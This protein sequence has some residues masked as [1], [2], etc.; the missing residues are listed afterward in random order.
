MLFWL[1]NKCVSKIKNAPILKFKQ[2][3]LVAFI[4]ALIGSILGTIIYL[5]AV[6][7]FYEMY[8]VNVF[9]G[10]FY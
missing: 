4:P 1:F 2:T 6:L 7:F 9:N 5:M 3:L 10:I 8:V